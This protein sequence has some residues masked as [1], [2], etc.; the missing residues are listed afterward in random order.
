MQ[1]ICHFEIPSLPADWLSI[2]REFGVRSGVRYSNPSTY[3]D[4]YLKEQYFDGIEEKGL[5]TILI[6]VNTI[7]VDE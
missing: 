2:D 1:K 7:S 4:V 3:C 6:G 5:G